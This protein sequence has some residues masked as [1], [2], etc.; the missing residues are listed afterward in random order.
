M[1]KTVS[2]S[3]NLQQ[4]IR[5]DKLVANSVA[6]VRVTH[7]TTNVRIVAYHDVSYRTVKNLWE[8]SIKCM[9]C[10][11]LKGSQQES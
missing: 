7:G 2:S 1:F 3:D 4:Y 9:L 6:E 10:F 11:H 5:W 8:K